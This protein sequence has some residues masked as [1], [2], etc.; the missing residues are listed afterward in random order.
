[1]LLESYFI[2]K[3]KGPILKHKTVSIRTTKVMKVDILNRYKKPCYGR[4]KIKKDKHEESHKT[5]QKKCLS[6]CTRTQYYKIGNSPEIN[7]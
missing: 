2:S 4:S 1:M 6:K 7:T 3:Y 5:S